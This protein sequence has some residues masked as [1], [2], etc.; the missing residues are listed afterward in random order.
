M[1]FANGYD[2][3]QRARLAKL[4]RP[5]I[6]PGGPT[7]AN[8]QAV[9]QFDTRPLIGPGG[10]R[11]SSMPAVG[12]AD[13]RSL[14]GQGGT[15]A[16]GML[17]VGQ[18][19]TAGLALRIDSAGKPLW[20]RA[21]QERK[22]PPLRFIDGAGTADGGFLLLGATGE[23]SPRAGDDMLVR[24]DAAG[25]MLWSRR[26]PN[27]GFGALRMVRALEAP[28]E[29]LLL[30]WAPRFM[31][32]S[33]AFIAHLLRFDANGELLG[34]AALAE[35]DGGRLFD[36]AAVPGGYVLVGDL[37]GIEGNLDRWAA[38]T[39]EY[40]VVG[41]RG[42]IVEID[43]NL[44]VRRS[45]SLLLNPLLPRGNGDVSLRIVLAP[46]RERLTVTGCIQ[47]KADRW[48]FAASLDPTPRIVNILADVA[49][50]GR[51]PGERPVASDL[52]GGDLAILLHPDSSGRDGTILR[53][54]PQLVPTGHYAAAPS[55]VRPIIADLHASAPDV[56][57]LISGT[58]E[59]PAE[60]FMAG[61]H[62]DFKCCTMRE[63]DP[64]ATARFS[65]AWGRPQVD[66]SPFNQ[67]KP[68]P[69]KVGATPVEIAVR[70]LCGQR[71][72]WDGERMVQSPHLNLQASGSD[73]TDASR[74]VLLRWFLT[75]A[76]ENHLP[77]GDAAKTALGFNKPDDQVSL[78]RAEWPEAVKARRLDLAVDRPV[79]VDDAKGVL[80]FETGAAGDRDRFVLRFLDIQGY[81]AARQTHD[82]KVDPTAFL[83]A[84]GARP[85][86]LELRARLAVACD[87]G[88]AANSGG[89]IQVEALS[90]ADTRLLTP[91]ELF[92]R[93]VLGPADGPVKRLV[94]ENMVGL[95][96]RCT[97]ARLQ[98]FGFICYEDVLATVNRAEGWSPLGRFALT[99]DDSTALRRLEEPARFKVD[100]LWR[101]YND[102]ACVR[103]KNYQDRWA[104]APGGLREGVRTYIQ[105]SDSDPAAT[106]PVAGA[107]PADGTIRLS[108]LD[109][110]QVVANTD[111]H[112]A[113]MLGLGYVDEDVEATGRCIHLAVYVTHGDLGDGRGPRAVQH[114]YMSLPTTLADSRP[115]LM[116]ELGAVQY[117]LAVP[118]ASGPPH[119]LTDA[120]GYT[121]DGDVRYVRLYPGCTRLY[122]DDQG[123]WTP[124]D[125]FDLS[126]ASLPVLYGIEHRLKSEQG[127]RPV[128]I[129]HDSAFLDTRT[130]PRPE[131]VPTPFPAQRY[132]RPFVHKV[133]EPGVGVYGAYSVSIFSRASPVCP[134]VTTDTTV[135]R[136]RN[137]LLPP[138][139]L[140]VQFIE[141]EA[142]LLL[143]TAWEQQQLAALPPGSDRTFVRLCCHYGFAQD[144]AYG[145]ADTIEIL[146]RRDIPGNVKGAL[147]S[148]TPDGTAGRLRIATQP[149]VYAS[150]GETLL[151]TLPTSLKAN[152]VGGIL[153]AGSARLVIEDIAWPAGGG[154]NSI[155][156]VRQPT[157]S[158]VLVNPLGENKLVTQDSELDLHPGDLVMAIENMAAAASWGAGNPLATTVAIGDSSWKTRVETFTGADGRTVSRTLRGV[159]ETAE[160]RGAGPGRYE[161]EFDTY[162]LAPHPQSGATDPVSW[163]RGEVRVPVDPGNLED[164]RA[165]RVLEV[166]AKNGRL[167]LVAVDDSG[168]GPVLQAAG[169]LVNYY[170]GY[171]V[172]LHAQPDPNVPANGFDWA[173]LTP[174]AGE[175]TRTT[176]LGVRSRDS[177]T[178]DPANQAYRSAVGAPQLVTAREIRDPLPPM[179][180]LGLDYATPPDIYHKSSY[181]MTVGFP[182]APFSI[183]FYRAAA[184][185][186]LEALYRPDTTFPALVAAIFP[187][188]KYFANRFAELFAFANGTSAAM[189][190]VPLE[191]GGTHLM[192]PPDH[193][194][195]GLTGQPVD[196]RARIKDALYR[197]FT[198]LTE[199]PLVYAYI[200]DKPDFVPTNRPQIVRN[201]NG[202]FLPAKDMDLAPMAKRTGAGH[203][204]QFTDFTLDGAMNPDTLYFYCAREI[205]QDMQ[206]SE[207]SPISK[208][209]KLINFTPPAPP[210]LRRM[211]MTPFD[212]AT[213]AN[214][215][216]SFELIEPSPLDPIAAV[217][218]FR[219]RDPALA[220]SL[221][222]ME[223]IGEFGLA[224]LPRT[225]DGSVLV[226]DDFANDPFVPYG[227]PLFYRLAWVREVHY[228]DT[229]GAARTAQ[230]PS[231]PSRTFLANVVDVVNPEPPVPV[232]T[233]SPAG[234]PD[235]R[236]VE[237][238]WS[239]TVHNGTYYVSQLHPSG[240]WTR[241]A[242]VTT[243]A[244]TATFSLPDPLPVADE[245][246]MPIFYRFKIG[247]A[248]S[249]GL[250]NLVDAP[251]TVR[252]DQP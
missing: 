192:P 59:V 171:K 37:G 103:V 90:A 124:S 6:G 233:A 88:F 58:E 54:D 49:L 55:P 193:P 8:M 198:P 217:R 116:P 115:P 191:G 21:C 101:K 10:S 194:E 74:G 92:S 161:I 35:K 51:T 147:A 7:A 178:K 230:V 131:A 66:T 243:N 112:A 60:V 71:V 186:I 81:G 76:L 249:S 19:D 241:I 121:A 109:M 72:D 128:E 133:V 105:L 26:V 221:R 240:N 211:T 33:R 113:R 100:G 200:S 220:L 77:K 238:S 43:R 247:A 12:E 95:R 166:T 174:A 45:T 218:L 68:T 214:P 79:H 252:L 14:S 210:Q 143:T 94:A 137:T 162:V 114:L 22:S 110:L 219:A 108:H 65:I 208:P 142:L 213:A 234:A 144:V 202:D 75:G 156:I 86:T 229:G 62:R 228:H 16:G 148:A 201:S 134:P 189:T 120:Q 84:Y 24:L 46:A 27:Q 123:F 236:M 17:A 47:E 117:G 207:A 223:Q 190:P 146:H 125:L 237:I 41:R 44:A 5:L 232:V 226:A 152:F 29:F 102:G 32:M 165:L 187:P 155:F 172:Y 85:V 188:D 73:G 69:A 11:A 206:M 64:R 183:V 83:A 176:I 196:D 139:D 231:E 197:A 122:A 140:L 104:A 182:H 179:Q 170:P 132:D 222:T 135:F 30:R 2:L 163:W 173:R 145:F 138:S 98:S 118:S 126:A 184:L 107:L 227:D 89:N 203:S 13:F 40:E 239:P 216:V 235:E 63:I 248:G 185:S 136:R 195:L 204:V 96:L 34:V 106:A 67:K 149:Y 15:A 70:R 38:M 177:L 199:Q 28:E 141:K 250:V 242:E 160:V 167:M 18:I 52:L 99:L 53:L 224:S 61:L 175:G 251:V 36:V 245:D 3:H 80:A 153:V 164:R 151:P 111:F 97:A 212:V 78:F 157:N 56:A 127:W 119:Q 244:P 130:P 129:G 181:T 42:V 1:K 154:A 158:G 82:P 168:A 93:Q 169:L 48:I 225:D 50:R 91:R 159:W 180:P 9:G 31:N 205:N 23:P 4:I 25:N 57:T 39:S 87:L 209:V 215:R 246:G 150:T 20:A